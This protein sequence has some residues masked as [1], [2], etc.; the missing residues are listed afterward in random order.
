MVVW[1]ELRLELESSPYFEQEKVVV[2]D[3]L[4][5]QLEVQKELDFEDTIVADEEVAFA[6]QEQDDA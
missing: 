1:Q 5:G 4:N 2:V 6:I 3:T